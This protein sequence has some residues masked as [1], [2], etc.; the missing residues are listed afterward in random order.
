MDDT[1]DRTKMRSER[2]TFPEKFDDVSSTPMLSTLLMLI[3]QETARIEPSLLGPV[4][5]MFMEIG[6]LELWE[7]QHRYPA[8]TEYEEWM[9]NHYRQGFQALLLFFNSA[10]AMNGKPT[11][12]NEVAHAFSQVFQDVDDVVNIREHRETVGENDDLKMGMVSHALLA[13]I[14]EPGFQNSLYFFWDHYRALQ[15]LPRHELLGNLTKL[16]ADPKL[17]AA[18]NELKGTL[19]R[20]GV[21]AALAK[22]SNDAERCVAA[23]PQFLQ[24]LMRELVGAFVGRLTVDQ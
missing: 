4:T 3:A 14:N 21:P 8:I 24:P 7:Y 17:H 12:T 16:N 11:L 23:T 6:T 18:Y 1:V 19:E 9:K 10:L 15:F 2:E 5:L 22:I 20:I 13:S